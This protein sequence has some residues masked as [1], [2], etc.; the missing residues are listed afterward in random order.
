MPDYFDAIFPT[1]VVKPVQFFVFLFNLAMEPEQMN[2]LG[3]EQK[4][5]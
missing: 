1:K 4:R 2:A 5:K 3:Q